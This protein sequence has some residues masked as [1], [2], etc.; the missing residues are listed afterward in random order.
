M[1]ARDA[2]ARALELLDVGFGSSVFG[3]GRSESWG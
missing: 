3:G 1:R 2:R